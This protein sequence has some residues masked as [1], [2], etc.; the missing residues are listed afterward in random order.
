MFTGGAG[1]GRRGNK[2]AFMNQAVD[3]EIAMQTSTTASAES[4]QQ[5]EVVLGA[6]SEH[7]FQAGFSGLDGVQQSK[8]ISTL[9]E[10]A[11][12][13]Y[14]G[15][16]R[17]ALTLGQIL[18]FTGESQI[19]TVETSLGTVCRRIVQRT[20]SAGRMACDLS[21]GAQNSECPA[22]KSNPTRAWYSAE[23]CFFAFNSSQ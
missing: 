8:I 9:T 10:N 16:R 14:V 20:L 3:Q 4:K 7:T 17:N 22:A 11:K 12:S 21:S 6:P 5:V 1:S 23:L 19:F 18:C 2:G 13:L 15:I